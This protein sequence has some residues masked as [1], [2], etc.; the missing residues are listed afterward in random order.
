MTRLDENAMDLK[1]QAYADQQLEKVNP[2]LAAS[3]YR[4]RVKMKS[5]CFSGA[6]IE[7]AF[8]MGYLSGFND[9]QGP[10]E[11]QVETPSEQ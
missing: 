3:M 5:P 4:R 6:S 9:G 2:N 7:L 1:A 11:E 10:R 8:K